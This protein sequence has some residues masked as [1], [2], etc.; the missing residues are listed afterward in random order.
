MNETQFNF[1][2]TKG[3]ESSIVVNEFKR[4]VGDIY[5]LFDNG[6]KTYIVQYIVTSFYKWPHNVDKI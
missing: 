6:Q 1:K 2:I 5:I 4:P 3:C